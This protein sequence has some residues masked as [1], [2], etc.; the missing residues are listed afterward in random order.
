MATFVSK[1]L[2]YMKKYLISKTLA[3]VLLC[4]AASIAMNPQS[5]LAHCTPCD[6]YIDDTTFTPIPMLCACYTQG[7]ISDPTVNCGAVTSQ[8]AFYTKS[9]MCTIDSI[10]VSGP[11]G[12]CW[13][14][15]CYDDFYPYPGIPLGGCSE[16]AMRLPQGI[17]I[18]PGMDMLMTIC[19]AT[20]GNIFTMDVYCNGS[21]TPCV[22]NFM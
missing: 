14:M 6:C 3:F 1:P 20:S 16:N 12:L 17:L 21:S 22:I 10:W 2:L 8:F 7:C 5:L 11:P 19:T 18:G 4:S 15:C 9:D 13:S